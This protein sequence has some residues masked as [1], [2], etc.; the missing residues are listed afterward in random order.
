MVCYWCSNLRLLSA[1]K[2]SWG[3]HCLR[4]IPRENT[5]AVVL[6]VNLVSD[7]LLHTLSATCACGYPVYIST[8]F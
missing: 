4:Y 7:S 1:L 5:G 6:S 8:V 2:K 3:E